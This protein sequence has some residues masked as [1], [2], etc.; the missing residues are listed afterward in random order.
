MVF[1]IWTRNLFVKTESGGG[2]GSKQPARLGYW[3]ETKKPDGGRVS[4]LTVNQRGV[5][6]F[7]FEI[8]AAHSKQGSHNS[9]FDAGCE[10][11]PSPTGVEK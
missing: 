7:V 4:G 6:V 3:P 9:L 5:L 8:M 1:R 10:R 2:E 11:A